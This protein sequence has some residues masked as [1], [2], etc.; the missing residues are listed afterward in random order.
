MCFGASSLPKRRQ[1]STKDIIM[2]SRQMSDFQRTKGKSKS[3]FL[4]KIFH[5][6]TTHFELICL[7]ISSILNVIR[8]FWCLL[9]WLLPAVVPF[10]FSCSTCLLRRQRKT[11]FFFYLVTPVKN[12]LSISYNATQVALVTCNWKLSWL[13]SV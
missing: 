5:F 9:N 4:T 2:S 6:G 11:G 8:G 12:S 10:M 1:C 7:N 3:L 13:I